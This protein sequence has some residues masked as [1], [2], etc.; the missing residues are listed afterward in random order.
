[1][2]DSERRNFLVLHRAC[3]ARQIPL[4]RR[5]YAAVQAR[6]QSRLRLVAARR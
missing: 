6:R 4:S 1:M 3:G 5:G 2:T